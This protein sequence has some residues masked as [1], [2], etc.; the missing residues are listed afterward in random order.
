MTRRRLASALLLLSWLPSFA[1]SA[2]GR[3][4]D[5]TL[6]VRAGLGFTASPTTF[7]M[8]IDVPFVITKNVALGPSFQLGVDDDTT[9]FAPTWNL[10]LRLPLEE[11]APYAFGGAGLAYVKKDHR[12][13]D[14]DDA[15]FLVDFGIGLDFWVSDEIALGSRMTF[16]FMPND[17]EGETF[18]FSWQVLTGRFSF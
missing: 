15:G 8:G 2:E 5:E 10:E 13:G 17:V 1:V 9:F 7:L 4:E 12:R 3:G 14:D 6:S 18:I 16:N 11:V